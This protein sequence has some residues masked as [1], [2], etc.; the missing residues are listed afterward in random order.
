MPGSIFFVAILWMEVE[1]RWV[2]AGQ[3]QGPLV[4]RCG[5]QEGWVETGQLEHLSKGLCVRP[6][7]EQLGW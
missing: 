3:L 7:E 6:Q 2:Q 1:F 4:W 5:A